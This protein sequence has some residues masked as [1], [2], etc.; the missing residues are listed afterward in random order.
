MS[1]AVPALRLPAEPQGRHQECAEWW[2]LTLGQVHL[3]DQARQHVAILNVEVVVG[4]EDV[5]G[6]DSSEGTAVL[7]EVGPAKAQCPQ[8][9]LLWDHL[10]HPTLASYRW[11]NQRLAK[12]GDEAWEPCMGYTLPHPTLGLS[13]PIP[14]WPQLGR[15][16]EDLFCTSIILLA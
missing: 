16:Q 12:E 8:G 9:P 4:P 15:L 10:P 14:G 5:G 11:K 1:E 6:D 7:L 3:V 13:S 2:A